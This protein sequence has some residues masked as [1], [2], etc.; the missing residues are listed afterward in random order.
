MGTRFPA[1]FVYLLFF[2]VHKR[3][4]VLHYYLGVVIVVAVVACDSNPSVRIIFGGKVSF[5]RKHTNARTRASVVGV[6]Q[7]NDVVTAKT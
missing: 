7:D 4:K 6:R 3:R 1:V 2:S 5:A